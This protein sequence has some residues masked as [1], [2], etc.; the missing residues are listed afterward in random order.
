MLAEFNVMGL[1]VN[2]GIEARLAVAVAVKITEMDVPRVGYFDCPREWL[3]GT[4]DAVA[5]EIGEG[6]I[7]GRINFNR[8]S[9]AAFTPFFLGLQGI[10][11]PVS[12]IAHLDFIADMMF[13][14]KS[15]C[16]MLL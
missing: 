9:K 16:A 13:A 3:E 8:Q 14:M 7:M 2:G 11:A 12:S 5:V 1:V 10:K 6:N 15:R 4:D